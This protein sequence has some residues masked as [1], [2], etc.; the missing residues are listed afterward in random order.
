[1]GDYESEE[2]TRITREMIEA[3]TEVYC[4]HCPDTGTGDKLDQRMVRDIYGAMERVRLRG[5]R[6]EPEQPDHARGQARLCNG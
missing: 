1:M 3:G 2:K 4:A 5:L 6:I